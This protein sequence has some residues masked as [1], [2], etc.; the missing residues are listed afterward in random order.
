MVSVLQGDI[1]A[2]EA[3]AIVNPWNCNLIPWRMLMPHGVSGRLK[4]VA[5]SAVFDEVQKYGKLKPG[6][7]VLTSAGKLSYKAIIHV[8]AIG[9]LGRSNLEIINLGTKNALQL[10]KAKSFKQV[11]F[12]LLGTGSGGVS[13]LESYKIM[14]AELDRFLPD[15]DS[16]ILIIFDKAMFEKLR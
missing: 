5:G 6:Q 13:P 9:L 14:R 15:F 8:A 7:A 2:V 3:D 16:L 4:Q 11:A 12:P 1:T 10:A